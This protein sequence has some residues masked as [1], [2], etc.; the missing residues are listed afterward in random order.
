LDELKRQLAESPRS[1]RITAV[2]ESDEP[3]D[4]RYNRFMI[5]GGW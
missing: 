5:E 2:E 4:K 1:A 3:V